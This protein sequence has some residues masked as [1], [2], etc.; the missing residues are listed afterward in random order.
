[1]GKQF[2]A[3]MPDGSERFAAELS[4]GRAKLF[5]DIA[6]LLERYVQLPCG[7]TPDPGDDE[8]RIDPELFVLFFE[9]VWSEGWLTDAHEGFISGWAAHA[10]GMIE[11]IFLRPR[12]W[13]DRNGVKLS[14]QRYL[15]PDEYPTP[16]Q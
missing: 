8:H 2:T 5:Y 9:R 15:R 10:A 3:I 1:M 16:T 12:S 14:I 6:L 7:I 13:V 4:M 11:N